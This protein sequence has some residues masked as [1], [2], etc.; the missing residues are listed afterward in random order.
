LSNGLAAALATV[1]APPAGWP[2]GA[3]EIRGASNVITADRGDEPAT[4]EGDAAV[5]IEFDGW[6]V[7]R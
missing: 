2:A 3:D 1:P 4:E 7:V 5:A 6:S